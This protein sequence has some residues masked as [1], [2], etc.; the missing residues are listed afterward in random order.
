MSSAQSLVR[1]G[2]PLDIYYQDSDNA[3][4]QVIP[5][6]TD[7]RYSQDFNNKGQGT[8]VFTIPPNSGVSHVIAV[9]GYDQA[10]ANATSA[11]YALQRGW[12]YEAIAQ[13]SFRIGGSSQYF[14]TGAQLLARNL[15]LARTQSQ[16]E[17]LLQ[18]GG[19]YTVGGGATGNVLAYIPISIWAQTGDDELNLPLPSDTLSQQIQVTIQLNPSYIAS[20]SPG[21]IPNTSGF[22]HLATGAA[23]GDLA[24]L[25]PAAFTTGYFQVQQIQMKDRG[26]ALAN[27]VDLSKEMYSMALPGGFDQFEQTFQLSSAD[28]SS[29]SQSV[30]LT[31]FRAG[32]VK[33]LQFF[34]SP[35]VISGN[36]ATYDNAANPYLWAAPQS[37]QVLYA[38][39]VYSNFQDGTGAMWNLLN[40][41]AP[42]AV[43]QNALTSA[44]GAWSVA[45]NPTLAQW[46]MA[47]FSQ[48]SGSDYE[49]DVLV[50]GL[51]ITNG[52]VNVSITPPP[53]TGV[54]ANVP[55]A[56]TLHVV[57]NYNCTLGFSRGTADL[58]F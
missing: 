50:H 49:A 1:V 10:T 51:E 48:P 9:V 27:R 46:T 29:G 20:S 17:A 25:P 33:S 53:M 6:L 43:N 28:A 35:N 34:L 13:V 38:G 39:L 54:A 21:V 37:L 44:A 52:I 12:G 47:S 31:G 7:Q 58:I 55:N 8:S 42:S 57:Y 30:V 36:A 11:S 3:K 14:L 5:T 26:M 41:T 24:P 45:T 2:S 32:E 22:W 18:L 4:K 40:G 23:G 56:W 19:S 15:R 16:R